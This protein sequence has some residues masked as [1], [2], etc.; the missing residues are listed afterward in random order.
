MN[1][2][3]MNDVSHLFK[4]PV[5]QDKEGR[6]ACPVCGKKYSTRAGVYRHIGEE[7]CAPAHLMFADTVTEDVAYDL[8]VETVGYYN[9]HQRFGIG[10]F[11]KSKYYKGVTALALHCMSNKVNAQLFCDWIRLVKKPRYYNHL[12]SL[13]M[14]DSSLVDFRKHL[15]R[16]EELIDSEQFFEQNEEML[17]KN[18]PFLIRSIQRGDIGLDFCMDHNDIDL[19]SRVESMTEADRIHLLAVV[20]VKEGK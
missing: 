2:E 17:L 13:G 10:S 6:F 18:T 3:F 14:K 5:K 4:E 7:A 8:F 19:G 1:R 20:S 12:L 11:R 16:N 9:K 15:V